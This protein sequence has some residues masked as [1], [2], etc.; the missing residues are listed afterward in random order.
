MRY[1]SLRLTTAL[2]G[3][4][5]CGFAA[6]AEQA[7]AP[8]TGAAV[9]Q[10]DGRIAAVALAQGLYEQVYSPSQDA[11]FVVSAG[12]FG[13]HAAPSRVLRLDPQS[14]AVQ[15]EIPLEKK[16]FGVTLD[17]AAGRL[18]VGAGLDA[19]V[20]VIDTAS[21]KVI[22]TIQLAEKVK[23]EAGEEG[24]PDHFRELAL[25]PQRHRLYAPGL[26]PQGSSLYVIDTQA[27]KVEK[28]LPGFGYNATGIA[29]APKGDV[30]YVSNLQGQLFT[31]D[32]ET[33]TIARKVETGA[34][35]LLNLALDAEGGRIFATDQG[36]P[37]V[38]KYRA[39]VLPD[40]KPKGEGNQVVVLDAKD[41]G[42]IKRLPTGEGP[43]GL[44]FDPE[45]KRLYVTNRPEGS[46]SVFDTESYALV[47]KFQTG[48]NPN[49][50]AYDAKRRALFVTVKSGDDAPEGG[51]ESVARIGL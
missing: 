32:A 51:D 20:I 10:Q 47:E 48:G 37:R 35:Q 6:Q 14:L 49:S 33:L 27:L 45:A 38:T 24:Y 23:D 16:G 5:L 50:L 17:D 28:V 9:I 25:D 4:I 34:D 40:Y 31:V 11:L 8:A 12:G 29:V 18:Y 41:G 22:G 2:A 7:S 15:A 46:V 1:L 36:H 44:R 26:R 30:I 43:V 19:A 3:L 39:E 21:N 13:D 42:E